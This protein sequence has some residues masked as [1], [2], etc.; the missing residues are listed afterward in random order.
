MAANRKTLK[1]SFCT[2]NYG[3]D[4]SVL[5]SLV[6]I[7][8]H[9]PRVLKHLITLHGIKYFPYQEWNRDQFSPQYS[10]W[11]GSLVPRPLGMRLT[12]WERGWKEVCMKYAIFV[13][14]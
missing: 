12:A 10:R 13:N 3:T 11:Q 2:I 5:H 8:T 7:L 1:V 14:Y 4:V 6:R 9:A